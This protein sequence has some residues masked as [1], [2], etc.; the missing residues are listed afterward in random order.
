MLKLNP[1]TTALVLIDLQEGILPFA[2]APHNA[3]DV[4]TRSAKLAER[5]REAQSTV[6]LVRVGWSPDFTDA[7]RQPVD[8]AHGG[9]ALP[10]NW[11]N[12]PAA[13]GVQPGDINVTKRQ[14]GAFYGTDLELQLR[15]R[16][17]DTLVLGGIATNMGVESTARN[18]W[19]LGFNLIVAE[20]MC[21]T[22]SRE[23]HEASVNWI[24]PRIAR[25]RQCD[26]VIAAL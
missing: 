16:G 15:R 21:S 4:I 12:F 22:A 17:V 2:Q 11:W 1:K 26:E 6:V 9:A 8:A 3:Y 19:E 7:L 23:Q 24:F 10:E 18:A 20:D 25:V 13:L 14:W 5:F